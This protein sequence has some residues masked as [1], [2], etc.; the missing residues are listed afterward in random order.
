MT[1]PLTTDATSAAAKIAVDLRTVIAAAAT[2]SYS[3]WVR[4]INGV[5]HVKAI[6]VA[7]P[8]ADPELASLRKSVLALGGSVYFRY[9]S[10]TALSVLLPAQRVIDI[11]MLA[12]VQ[13]VSPNR[14]TARTATSLA[15]SALEEATGV[16][17]VRTRTAA[18]YSGLDGS[19]VGIAILDSGVML[20]HQLF[21]DAAG[22]SRVR[23]NVSFL[24]AGDA[25][26][27]GAKD[28][29]PGIDASAGLY[30][31]SPSMATYES[32]IDNAATPMSDAYGHGSHVEIGR[33][34]V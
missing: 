30:P 31:G 12:D 11:A 1:A 34:H 3:N 22:V 2:P 19:G 16:A 4:D 9:T 6:V 17:S 10:V 20:K 33:A 15:A 21:N 14:V 25:T 7:T 23:K 27:A 26:A 32:K 5:R 13:G 18:G 8:S 28:W 24:R 29:R